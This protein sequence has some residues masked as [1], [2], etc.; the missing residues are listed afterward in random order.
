MVV[1]S[2]DLEVRVVRSQ[3]RKRTVSARI[4]G[5]TLVVNLPMSMSH[6]EEAEWVEKMAARLKRR[7]GA[8]ELSREIDL[9]ARARELNRRYFQDALQY[10]SVQFVSNQDS[11]YGSCTPTGGHIRISGRV[12]QFPRWVL[13]YV[14]MHE[15]A[16]LLQ[17]NHS[18][19]FWALVN[20]Y[21][22]AE[23]ARGY[24][25]AKGLEEAEG[26]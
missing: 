22:L 15:L 7:M 9:A 6:E 11:R 1:S 13:D 8:R 3:R 26:A 2:S 4:V 10:A 12:G 19:A 5:D 17:A 25:I 20:R 21:P 14:L 16:H 24:L 18:Q 23:R